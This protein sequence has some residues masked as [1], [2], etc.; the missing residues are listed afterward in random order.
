MA[1]TGCFHPPSQS[2]QL[3]ENI[4]KMLDKYSKHD[5]FLAVGDFNTEDL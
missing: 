1:F 2:V 4:R 3:F 5:K